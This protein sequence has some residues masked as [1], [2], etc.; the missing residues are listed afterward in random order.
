MALGDTEISLSRSIELSH[1]YRFFFFFLSK[2]N[3]KRPLI[4]LQT[5]ILSTLD[6]GRSGRA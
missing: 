3:V 4:L 5:I 1:C 6:M 2:N